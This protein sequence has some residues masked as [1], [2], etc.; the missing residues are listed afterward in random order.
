MNVRDVMTTDAATVTPGTSLKEVARIL[1][2]R[3][4][5]GVPVVDAEGG[6]LG[7]VSETDLL[8]KER[9]DPPARGGPLAWL[10][11]PAEV[12]ERRKLAA[13]L[14]GEV[15]SAPALTIAPQRSLATAA[16]W[17]L[18]HRVNRLPV[19]EHGKL[20]GIVTRA[21][22]VRAF[23]RPDAEIAR[24]IRGDV[25]GRQM[26]LDDR[27]VDV[28]V[29]AGEVVLR[30]VFGR[31]SQAQLMPRLVARVAGV[32]GVESKLTW[33]EDDTARHRAGHLDDEP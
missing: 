26:L 30:G 5:S 12:V 17:M 27:A 21:D 23:A 24:E 8:A 28:E 18:D 1:V 4:I 13:R 29:D 31:R 16:G 9:A 15:M 32:V 33:R 11:D 2:D 25:L 14:A 6:V 7:V 3:G 19:V 22:L 20:V 10:V